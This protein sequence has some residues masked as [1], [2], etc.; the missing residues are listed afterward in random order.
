MR[1]ISMVTVVLPWVTRM[2]ELKS[3][4]RLMVFRNDVFPALAGP[5]IP[6]ISFSRMSRLTPWSATFWPYRML[7]SLTSTLALG[8]SAWREA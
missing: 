1:S 3:S 6:K 2:L 5:M 7:R 8:P 4:I